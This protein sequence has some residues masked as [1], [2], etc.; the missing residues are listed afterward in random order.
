[1]G[2]SAV[3]PKLCRLGG[4]GQIGQCWIVLVQGGGIGHESSGSFV[5]NHFAASATGL[6]IK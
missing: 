4:I 1:M 5:N 2:A 6:N 3:V